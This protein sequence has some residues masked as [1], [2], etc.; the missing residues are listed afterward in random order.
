MLPQ[1]QQD[2][3]GDHGMKWKNSLAQKSRQYLVVEIGGYR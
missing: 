2:T 3:G 1:V